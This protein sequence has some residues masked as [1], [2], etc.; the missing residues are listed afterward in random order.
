MGADPKLPLNRHGFSASRLVLG[1]MRFAGEWSRS[2]PL[3][4]EHIR[5]MH[6]AVDAALSVGINMFDHADIYKF[7]KAEEAFGRVLRERPGL[8]DS[9]VIQSKCGIRLREG[10][11]GS[12]I[13][14]FSKAHI[15]ASVDGILQRLGIETL[16]VLL[17]HRPDPLVDPE[18][19]AEAFAALKKAG[20]VKRFGVSNMSAG[21]MKFLQAY[22][23]EPLVANQL[24]MSLLKLDW[25]D[26]GVHVNQEE[27]KLSSFPDGTIEYCR[28]NNVQIQ[29]WGPLATGLLTGRKAA[30]A[31]PNVRA[32]AELV[33]RKAQEKGVSPEAILIAFLLRH[34]ARIQPVIGTTRPDRIHACAEAEKVELTR[35]E[36]YE[37]YITSR[38]RPMP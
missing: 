31:A 13:F 22:L 8:R 38:G 32:A 1:C 37:L 6:E 4:A 35:E 30:D 7:G 28:L 27:G 34:P 19:V 29:A 33:A 10:P 17:L 16:D 5:E 15:L 2:D 21:Q 18:E 9:I 20:K 26:A 24:E 36:W 14:D 25:L 11:N 23:D 3:T 12:S